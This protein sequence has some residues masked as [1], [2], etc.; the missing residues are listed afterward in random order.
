MSPKTNELS[1]QD[2][3]LIKKWNWGAFV[4]PVMWGIGNK[5]YWSL[6]CMIPVFG[7][8]WRFVSG[9]KG[10]EWAYKSSG[11]G[12]KSTL[13]IQESWNRAG[14]L[15]L[16]IAIIIAVLVVLIYMFFGLLLALRAAM[17]G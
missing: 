1:A 7:W 16:I 15:V 8:F 5:A 14:K 2:E 6:L 4:L 11:V 17:A 3:D 12:P 9:L 13:K 10:N